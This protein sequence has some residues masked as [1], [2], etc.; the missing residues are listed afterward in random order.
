MAQTT[1]D[2]IRD[3]YAAIGTNPDFKTMHFWPG[4]GS[5]VTFDINFDGGYIDRSHVRAFVRDETTAATTA[6]SLT[7]D[8]GS[9]VRIATPVPVGSTICVYRDTPKNQPLALFTDGAI[10][11]ASNLDRNSKQAIFAASE[12]LDRFDASNAMAEEAILRASEAKTAAEGAAFAAN[13]AENSASVAQQAAVVAQQN[14]TEA[15]ADA[16]NALSIANS[17]NTTATGIDGKATQA[18]TTAGDAVTTANEAK[19]TAEGIEGKADTAISTAN[20]AVGTANTAVTKANQA[21]ASADIANT[22]AGSAVATANG[23]EAKADQAISTANTAAKA[24]NP[25]LSTAWVSKRSAMWVGF[26]AGDGQE[27]SRALY[28]DAW[29]AINAGLV[30]VCTKAEWIADPAKRGC[31]HTG[32]GSTTFGL[33]DYNGVQPGSYG[34]VYLGGGTTDGGT[35]L[36]DRIQNITGRF[37]AWKPFGYNDPNGGFAGAFSPVMGVVSGNASGASQGG[38]D[39]N[40]FDFDASRVARTGDTTRPITAEGC[41]AIKLFGA[42]QNTG[43]ADAAALATAVAALAAR[44]TALEARKFT[45]IV[46]ATYPSGAPHASDETVSASLP[47]SV[48]AN[49]E[50]VLAEPFGAGVPVTLKAQLWIGGFWCD[51]GW[52]GNAT[53][54]AYGV[55]ARQRAGYGIV[56]QTGATGVDAGKAIVGSGAGNSGAVTTSAP[57]RVLV[58]RMD[59]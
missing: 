47:A 27:L 17:A 21:I 52:D 40:A 28:P 44:V 9:R 55:V 8:T 35:I 57:C 37:N 38:N 24:L 43:S 41:I 53:D 30:P 23:I 42:V 11:N 36:R 15:A 46:P 45:A 56:V 6:I 2:A 58:S 39:P 7:F 50:Y 19:T 12:L 48:V 25:V 5:T 26:A 10:L 33:P 29:A 34:P 32:D 16:S 31:F 14:A 4:D 49:M 13:S 18:L 20:S 3:W 22:T 54:K 59:M 1:A 51:A